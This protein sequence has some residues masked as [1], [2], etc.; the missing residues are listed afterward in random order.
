MNDLNK[1][2]EKYSDAV[3]GYLPKIA[4]AI[5]A[6]II[7]MWIVGKLT[8]TIEKGLAKS[9]L[10]QEIIPFI[11]SAISVVLK[12]VVFLVVAG[13]MG[14]E[15]ASFAA[16][17]AA[18][19]FAVGMAL[20]GSLGHLAAGILI[21]IFKPYKIGDYIQV[22][23]DEGF[24]EEIRILNTIIKTLDNRTVIIPNGKAIDDAI[25][26]SSKNESV[27]LEFF[28]FMPYNESFDKVQAFLTEELL[29]NPKILKDPAPFIGIEEFES[30]SI[31]LVIR[32]YCSIEDYE[33]VYY[34]ATAAVKSALGRNKVKVAYSEDMSLGDIAQ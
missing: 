25:T 13:I 2:I 14:I 16:A 1:Y 31:K 33:Q 10:S 17:I 32:P 5:F 11:N 23:D 20:Q 24:V 9:G 4:L 22:G 8:K 28:T 7:G 27:R 12:I 34:E 3:I 29:K 18:M 30:H 26:N 21:L 19:S 6:F 15:T